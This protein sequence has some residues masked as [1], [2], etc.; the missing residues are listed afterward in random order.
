MYSTANAMAATTT[1]R[2]VATPPILVCV[3]GDSL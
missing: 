1:Q 3:F 2:Q